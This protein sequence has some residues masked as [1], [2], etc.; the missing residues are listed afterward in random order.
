[1]K[2]RIFSIL[3]IFCFL[4]GIFLVEPADGLSSS[5]RT[6]L[7]QRYRKTSDTKKGS[8]DADRSSAR[9]IRNSPVEPNFL[10]IWIAPPTK[11]PESKKEPEC[12]RWVL[13][14][15]T[16]SR[17][18]FAEVRFFLCK[19]FESTAVTIW[20]AAATRLLLCCYNTNRLILQLNRSGRLSN[21]PPLK[22]I[23]N[24]SFES[25]SYFQTSNLTSPWGL[26]IYTAYYNEWRRYFY[27]RQLM[28]VVS[29][30]SASRCNI[31]CSTLLWQIDETV[32]LTELARLDWWS[33]AINIVY[34][35][36]FPFKFYIT[37]IS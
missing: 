33:Y 17:Q 7:Q 25:F 34:I 3:L 9:S 22:Q 37:R 30:S 12:H 14:K 31:D 19:L 20:W 21:G 28:S 18:K 10:R 32:A 1:M 15:G 11:N 5:W 24:F 16:A 29:D 26:A 36:M 13:F 23:K 4:A 2:F 8:K 6:V 27:Q 35:S